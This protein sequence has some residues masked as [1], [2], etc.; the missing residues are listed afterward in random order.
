MTEID[1]E[2]VVD[3][4][5]QN[6]TRDIEAM[7]SSLSRNDL[8]DH[9][10]KIIIA[11]DFATTVDR[12]NRTLFHDIPPYEAR[13]SHVEAVAK[14]IRY[15]QDQ[16]IKFILVFSG[17]LI[18]G[19]H[20]EPALHALRLEL[21]AH[22]VMH[23]VL[24]RAR[25]ER[26]GPAAFLERSDSAEEFLYYLALYTR[27]EYVAN[28][29]VDEILKEV[30][31]DDKGQPIGSADLHKA[32]FGVGRTPDL[33]SLL[34]EMYSLIRKKVRD[35]KYWLLTLDDLWPLI[36][37]QIEQALT[38]FAYIAAQHDKSPQWG[39]IFEE[40]SA[41]KG[42]KA[43][44]AEHWPAIHAEWQKL[45]DA[46]REEREE[47]LHQISAELRGVFRKCG[48]ELSTTERG[49]YISVHFIK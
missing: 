36:V 33:I 32:L 29:I 16:E 12:I 30:L 5:K 1:V 3:H 49:M 18:G 41:T 31:T 35:F 38:L 15:V 40:I 25:F 42:Y 8:V 4:Q 6:A 10:E 37:G 19:W 22:E 2:G 28:R 17:E 24:D 23:T 45:F 27:D 44:F 14:T 26:L 13:L 48:V 46:T 34:T 11:S 20:Q 9:I 39:E 47:S 7:L 43:L 21:I